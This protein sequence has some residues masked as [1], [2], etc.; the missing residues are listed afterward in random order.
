MAPG[1][2]SRKNSALPARSTSLGI[3][4][5]H[6]PQRQ[7]RGDWFLLLELDHP[8]AFPCQMSSPARLLR[9]SIYRQLLPTIHAEAYGSQS[10]GLDAFNRHSSVPRIWADDFMNICDA[11]ACLSRTSSINSG[12]PI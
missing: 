1:P 6:R 5:F 12:L 7:P 10:A 3:L 8:M 9:I 11:T 2:S 4:Y